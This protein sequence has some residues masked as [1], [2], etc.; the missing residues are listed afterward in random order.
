MRPRSH[1]LTVQY[2]ENSQPLTRPFHN[3][4]KT[5]VIVRIFFTL[6]PD[7]TSET[8]SF[9]HSWRSCFPFAGNEGKENWD[10]GWS[11]EKKA[12]GDL[13]LC[14]NF[15][16]QSVLSRLQRSSMQAIHQSVHHK[17]VCYPCWESVVKWS[18]CGS[19]CICLANWMTGILLC[20]DQPRRLLFGPL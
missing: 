3:W 7:L 8:H 12:G 10:L 6:Q 1:P 18:P 15:L 20:Q 14:C 2:S 11:A 4:A 16:Q 19:F 9:I 5:V 17:V 13:D